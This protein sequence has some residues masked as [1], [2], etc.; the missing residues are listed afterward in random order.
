MIKRPIKVLKKKSMISATWVIWNNLLKMKR[1]GKPFWNFSVQVKQ[2]I[3]HMEKILLILNKNILI[4]PTRKVK[5]TNFWKIHS[6]IKSTMKILSTNSNFCKKLCKLSMK[7]MT[8]EWRA[9]MMLQIL[10]HLK[11][12]T[13]ISHLHLLWKKTFLFYLQLINHQIQS[14]IIDLL[15]IP[16]LF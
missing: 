6:I 8:V 13:E 12:N 4:S 1:D 3:L 11:K 15:W 7:H 14:I 16:W 5:K 10:Q 9:I 2:P